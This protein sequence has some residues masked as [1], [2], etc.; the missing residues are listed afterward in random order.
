M[1]FFINNSLLYIMVINVEVI[2]NKGKIYFLKNFMLLLYSYYVVNIVSMQCLY[3]MKYIN[4]Y[5]V[6]VDILIKK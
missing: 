4:D 1:L 2:D 3:K 5:G 6:V